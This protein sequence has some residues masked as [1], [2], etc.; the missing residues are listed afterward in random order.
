ME[1]IEFNP[2]SQR[3][4]IRNPMQS[5]D[6]ELPLLQKAGWTELS[7]KEKDDL[8]PFSPAPMRVMHKLRTRKSQPTLA[9]L[10]GEKDFSDNV[11]EDQRLAATVEKVKRVYK[12]I[13]V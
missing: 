12:P 6:S 10:F 7:D 3:L 2:R 1:T 5:R 9:V 13:D 11:E 8:L 4:T